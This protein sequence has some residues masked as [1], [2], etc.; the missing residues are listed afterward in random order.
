VGDRAAFRDFFSIL[1]HVVLDDELRERVA[2]LYDWYRDLY[3]EGLGDATAA[4]RDRLRAFASLMVAMTDGLA[5]Q[6]LLDPD[7]VELEPLFALW[8]DML[9]RTL[10]P[11]GG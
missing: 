5:V 9:R 3:V 10:L 1:P 8:E 6:K 11:P 2:A 7:G 4:D